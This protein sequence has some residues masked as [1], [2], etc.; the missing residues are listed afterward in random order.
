MEIKDL[1]HLNEQEIKEL[2]CEFYN[3]LDNTFKLAVDLG[4]N[5]L[6]V[7]ANHL[8]QPY[9]RHSRNLLRKIKIG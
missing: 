5:G 4:K 3:N 9:I 1:E 7:T 2:F 8:F 6:Q